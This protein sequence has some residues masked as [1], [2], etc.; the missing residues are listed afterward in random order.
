MKGPILDE[1]KQH[2]AKMAQSISLLTPILYV[3]ILLTALAVFSSVYRR[4]KMNDLA[5]I[6]PWYPENWAREIYLSLKEQSESGNQK[7]PDKLLK[8]ALV[9]WAAE[10][11]RQLLRMREG[12]GVLTALHQKGSVGDDVWKRFTTS[13]KLLEL[14]LNEVAQEANSLKEGWAQKLFQTAT[15]VTQNEALRKR[16]EEFPEQQ[17]DFKETYERIRQNSL[18]ELSS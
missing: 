18:E 8:S 7:V 10:D 4:R 14:E 12:K 16:I 13:E 3:G 2:I 11:V 9:K 1:R 5:K 15:E 17:S 6:D